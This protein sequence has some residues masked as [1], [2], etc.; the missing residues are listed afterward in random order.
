MIE[1]D[2]LPEMGLREGRIRSNETYHNAGWYNSEGVKVGWGDLDEKDLQNIQ[3]KL[4]EGEVFIVLGEHDS[5]WNFVVR[6]AIIGSMCGTSPTEQ[7]PGQDYLIQHAR[8][9]IT[10]DK[11]YDVYRDKIVTEDVTKLIKGAK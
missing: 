8:C 10:R 7:N 3:S 4:E 2:R 5:F 6:P 1:K 11:I 9:I